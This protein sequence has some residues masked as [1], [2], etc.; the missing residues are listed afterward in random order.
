MIKNRKF[1]HL[2]MASSDIEATV[3]WYT[4]N[5]GYKVTGDFMAPPIGRFVFIENEEGSIYE[6]YPAGEN[7]EAGAHGKIAHYCF[8]SEDI[9]KDY[10]Y[11]VEKGY[12]FTTNGIEE[13]PF[14]DN[15]IKYFKISAP[16]GQEI[17]FCQ[18]L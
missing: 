5:L 1:G 4:E 9:E 16:T 12:S 2:G 11:C 17:E 15:G 13:L 10:E 3:A 8:D 6:I 7:E 14:W 18:I